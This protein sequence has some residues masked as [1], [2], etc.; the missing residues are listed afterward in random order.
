MPLVSVIKPGII[1]IRPTE[2][3]TGDFVFSDEKISI[4]ISKG[5]LYI[6]GKTISIVTSVATSSPN[7]NSK[8]LESMKEDLEKKIKKLRQQGSIEEIERS[9]IKLEKIRADIKLSRI[10][11][12]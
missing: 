2:Q 3:H 6:D 12:G 4:S 1:S 8:D 11:T 7:T 10:Q 9:L 5:M